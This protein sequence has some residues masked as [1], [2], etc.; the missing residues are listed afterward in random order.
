VFLIKYFVCRR[1][2]LIETASSDVV[3]ISSSENRLLNI[4]RRYKFLNYLHD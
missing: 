1:T 2:R 3:I 4:Y